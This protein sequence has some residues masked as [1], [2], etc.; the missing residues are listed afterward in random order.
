[1]E[2]NNTIQYDKICIGRFAN[3]LVKD[4][5]RFNE[6]MNKGIDCNQYLAFEKNEYNY[7]HSGKS[8]FLV[9]EYEVDGVQYRR[10]HC[11]NI[12]HYILKKNQK[13]SWYRC[14]RLN[15]G[16]HGILYG[17][18]CG[19]SNIIFVFQRGNLIDDSCK[20]PH[21]GLLY[22]NTT[23]QTDMWYLHKLL[24]AKYAASFNSIPIF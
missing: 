24:F 5:R 3:V 16:N 19:I 1:M 10:A 21:N 11:S 14:N 13:K 23:H 20:F 6:E 2:E 7:F 15:F 9:Y 17:H 4:G 8:P 12:S 18:Q 22:K